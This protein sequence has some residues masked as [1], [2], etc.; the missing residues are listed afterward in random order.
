MR[1]IG[2]CTGGGQRLRSGWMNSRRRPD[3]RPRCC[4]R[5]PICLP[6]D[7]GFWKNHRPT[8]PTPTAA[9]WNHPPF[10]PRPTSPGRLAL[11]AQNISAHENDGAHT[12]EVS[13][14]MA[15]DVGC[16]YA[17]VGHSERRAAGETDDDCAQKIAAA[18]RAGLS[19]I[20]CIGETAAEDAAGPR[21]RRH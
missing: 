8:A 9:L 20:L 19:P 12:G 10:L 5:R 6:H 7:S 21:P 2:K 4:R 14:R 15:A 3:A 18:L 17:L 13:A 11:G 1:R 16:E